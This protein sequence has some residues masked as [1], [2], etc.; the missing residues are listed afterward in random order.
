MTGLCRTVNLSHYRIE[1]T[2]NAIIF[3]IFLVSLVLTLSQWEIELNP[4]IPGILGHLSN[5]ES[6][7]FSIQKDLLFSQ[8]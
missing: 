4:E 7:I 6:R 1:F 5:P 8:F 3:E 2:N